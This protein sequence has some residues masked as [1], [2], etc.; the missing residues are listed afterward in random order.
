MITLAGAAIVLPDRVLDEGAVVIEGD[1]IVEVRETAR[2][3]G[4]ATAALRGGYLV[5]GFID[6]HVHGVLGIDALESGEAVAAMAR[7]LPRFG[8]TAF[9]PT[10]VACDPARLARLLEAV[11]RART[12]RDPAAARVLPAHLESNFLNPAWA[13]AQPVACLRQPPRGTARAAADESGEFTADEILAVMDRAAPDIGIVTLAPELDG[14]VAL[15]RQLAG[16]GHRVSLGHS[17]ATYEQALEALA[18]GA[19]HVTHLFNRMRALSHRD[20]G[21]VGA[22]LH[23]DELV[24]ELVC[25]GQHVHAA[26]AHVVV[27]AKSPDRV[28]AITDGTAGAGLPV[29][30]RATLGGRTIT[31]GS[32]AQYDDGTMAGSVATMDRAFAWLVGPVGLSLVEA[33]RLCATT[34]AQALGLVGHGLIAPGAVADL[35]VLDARL[36]VQETYIGGVCAYRR[37]GER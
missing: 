15:I 27:A 23:S 25:D 31:V 20:P 37:E 2:G 16:R 21:L 34:P 18:A 28:M 4:D 9:C 7:A 36:R 10:S 3:A 22:A 6:V 19:R 14:A 35:V 8:V 1:R 11:G 17:G 13:G 30:A 29:G 33:A 24:A 12:A 32:T 5:P 26:V